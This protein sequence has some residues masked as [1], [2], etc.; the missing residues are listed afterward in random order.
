[1]WFRKKKHIDLFNHE[2]VRELDDKVSSILKVPIAKVD[3]GIIEKL[4]KTEQE[5]SKI[6]ETELLSIFNN[7]NEELTKFICL[8]Y[9]K[10]SKINGN[11]LKVIESNGLSQGFSI[12]YAIYY[13][14]LKNDKQSELGVY[15]S[16]RK[17]PQ[18]HKFHDRL[19]NYFWQSDG[20]MLSDSYIQYAAGY[21]KEDVKPQDISKAIQDLQKMDDEHG[22]FW[23]SVMSE[24]DEFVIQ[25]N[26]LKEM[27]LIQGEEETRVTCAN[28]S[29]VE[30]IFNLQI[31]N[32]FDEIIRRFKK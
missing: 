15:L 20:V 9:S 24:E 1:M 5:L 26:K 2:F 32:D 31:G 10:E 3:K 11:Q 25:T 19:Q 21:E 12:T 29:E 27:T 17:I 14:F 8:A 30:E 13:F 7:N 4:S 22:A 6:P 16:K 28:W 23:V 18:S